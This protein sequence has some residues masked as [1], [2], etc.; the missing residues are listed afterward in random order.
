MRIPIAGLIV[1]YVA[2]I[3]VPSTQSIAQSEFPLTGRWGYFDYGTR[4]VSPIELDRVC[5]TEWD[6]YAPDGAFVGFEMDDGGRVSA[7][8]AGFCV[9]F[10][11]EVPCHYLADYENQGEEQVDRGEIF[12]ATPDIVDYVLY[13]ETGKLNY[14]DS[15][16]YIRCPASAGFS[17]G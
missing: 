4:N 11:Q 15:W 3:L 6:S 1:A 2:V 9:V 16:T 14:E 12:Y 13:G 5:M 8:F 7:L 17:V 10:G